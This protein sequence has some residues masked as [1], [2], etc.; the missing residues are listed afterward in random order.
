VER[1]CGRAKWWSREH[2]MEKK[3][4]ESKGN[5]GIMSITR[6]ID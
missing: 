3:E 5:K 1:G 4:R 6:L 2:I